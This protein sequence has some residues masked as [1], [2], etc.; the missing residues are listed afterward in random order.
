MPRSMYKLT[1]ALSILLALV[2]AGPAQADTQRGAALR[3][4]EHVHAMNFTGGEATMGEC[5]RDNPRLIVCSTSITGVPNPGTSFPAEPLNCTLAVYSY[6]R[7]TG[8]QH[9]DAASPLTC[10]SE[11]S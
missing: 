2:L 7:R 9:A 3:Y 11:P 8:E 5:H 10:V 4:A 6:R 1:F